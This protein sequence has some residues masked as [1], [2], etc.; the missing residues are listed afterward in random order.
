MVKKAK[1]IIST[2]RGGIRMENVIDIQDYSNKKDIKIK[3]YS[4][5]D[6]ILNPKKRKETYEYYDSKYK[7]NDEERQIFEAWKK[8]RTGRDE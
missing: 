3:S 8:R 5:I 4:I 1:R 2:Y 6:M 7:E